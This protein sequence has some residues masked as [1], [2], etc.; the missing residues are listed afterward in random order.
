MN[1]TYAIEGDIPTR[2]APRHHRSRRTSAAASPAMAAQTRQHFRSQTLK[3]IGTAK[4]TPIRRYHLRS[5]T[6]RVF[7]FNGS[8]KIPPSST[9]PMARRRLYSAGDKPN[10]PYPTERRHLRQRRETS[11][12]SPRFA[13]SKGNHRWP[14]ARASLFRPRWRSQDAPLLAVCDDK[15]SRGRR[16]SGKS[17]PLRICDGGCRRSIQLQLFLR[18]LR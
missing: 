11:N 7:T 8:A 3:T 16:R 6:K 17:S 14:L 15:V 5:G 12:L 10:S 9:L 4:T 1:A 13:K 2:Q 18:I